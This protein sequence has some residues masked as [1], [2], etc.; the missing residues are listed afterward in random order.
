VPGRSRWRRC[1]RKEGWGR[2]RTDLGL[3]TDRARYT[4]KGGA[5]MTRTVEA[6]YEEGVLRPVEPLE[7]VAEHSRVLGTLEI[8]HVAAH[9]LASCIGTLPDEDAQELQR[10]IE[11][12]FERVDAE[13]WR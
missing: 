9:P 2:R 1:R 13:E 11:E 3:A 8:P 12:E 7:G 10:I 6:F 5:T 4:P